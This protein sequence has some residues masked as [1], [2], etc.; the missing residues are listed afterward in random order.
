MTNKLSISP[1]FEKIKELFKIVK[2]LETIKNFCDL[3]DFFLNA[4]MRSLTVIRLNVVHIIN[5]MCCSCIIY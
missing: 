2:Q 5:K 4:A 1:N 3:Y